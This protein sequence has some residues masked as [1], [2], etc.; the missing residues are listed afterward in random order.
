MNFFNKRKA[1]LYITNYNLEGGNVIFS[2][3]PVLTDYTS[4]TWSE[5][6]LHNSLKPLLTKLKAKRVILTLGEGFINIVNI[7]IP[8]NLPLDEERTYILQE[9]K[10]VSPNTAEN[11]TWKFKEIAYHTD[12]KEILAYAPITEKYQMLITALQA[13]KCSVDCI[14][15]DIVAKTR[16]QNTLIGAA[17]ESRDEKT[18]AK[19]PLLQLTKNVKQEIKHTSNT[20][21]KGF[22]VIIVLLGTGLG[23]WLI[24]RNTVLLKRAVKTNTPTTV[25]NIQETPETTQSTQPIKTEEVIQKEEF[26]AD[27]Y[28]IQILNGTTVEGLAARTAKEFEDN[29]FVKVEIGNAEA[30]D[31]Q[32]TQLFFS[33]A[34]DL[35]ELKLVVLDILKLDKKRIQDGPDKNTDYD[36]TIILGK[37][38]EI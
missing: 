38:F 29:G 36:V 32:N 5:D 8:N 19:E 10:K 6:G 11:G 28:S 30:S 18:G 26:M 13:V 35:T 9:I 27:K 33:T 22:I 21:V 2:K 20:A 15:P 17:I 16:H 25:T 1:V 14:E 3:E 31:V 34:E 7:T 24:T 23:G 4:T 12:K 37:D